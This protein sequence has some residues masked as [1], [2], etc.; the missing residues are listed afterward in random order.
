MS[1]HFHFWVSDLKSFF[2]N[3]ETFSEKQ[4]KQDGK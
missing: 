4:D 3:C 1:E 2:D